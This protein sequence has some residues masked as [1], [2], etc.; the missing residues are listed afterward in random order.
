MRFDEL[1]D[2]TE[3]LIESLMER[4]SL[5]E[6]LTAEHRAA[7]EQH[8]KAINTL[9][10]GYTHINEEIIPAAIDDHEERAMRHGMAIAPFL[11]GLTVG[12]SVILIK[13]L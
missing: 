3:S 5:M 12:L 2:T 13:I 9:V 7:L 4:Q 10:D 8:A 11:L 1:P 6:S